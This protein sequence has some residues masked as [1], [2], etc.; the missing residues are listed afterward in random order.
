MKLIIILLYALGALYLGK[1]AVDIIDGESTFITK[2]MLTRAERKEN[3]TEYWNNIAFNGIF[4]VGFLAV[5]NA[6]RKEYWSSI[7]D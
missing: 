3:P 4:G 1:T 5:G 7:K 6:L 2:E